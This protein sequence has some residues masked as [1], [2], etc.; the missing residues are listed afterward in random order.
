MAQPRFLVS[1]RESVV[2]VEVHEQ[3]PTSAERLVHTRTNEDRRML[4]DF[5]DFLFFYA[6]TTG[7]AE[8][9]TRRHDQ[10]HDDRG[11]T[12]AGAAARR[13]AAGHQLVATRRSLSS[14]RRGVHLTAA[15]G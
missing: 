7:D 9:M 3:P 13:A 15:T 6:P 14:V 11:V 10:W 5:V 4:V 2:W 8:L 12:S 1:V